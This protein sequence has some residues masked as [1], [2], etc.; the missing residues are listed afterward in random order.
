MIVARP[1]ARAS[2]GFS[3]ARDCWGLLDEKEARQS[4]AKVEK[5]KET[6]IAPFMTAA[7]VAWDKR[8]IGSMRQDSERIR[9]T[10]TNP[11]SILR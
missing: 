2:Q 8:H 9:L 11:S 7:A 3:T 5:G 1:A 4:R 10:A 6:H